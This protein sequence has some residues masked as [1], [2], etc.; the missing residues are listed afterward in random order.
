MRSLTLLAALTAALTAATPA[1]AHG[2]ADHSLVGTAIHYLTDLA[3][4]PA[5]W[6]GIVAVA[7]VGAMAFRLKKAPNR[8]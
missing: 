5:F 7:V 1:F 2:Q 4:A 8:K 3:H 6:A